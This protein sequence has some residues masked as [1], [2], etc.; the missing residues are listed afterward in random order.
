MQQSFNANMT[1]GLAFLTTTRTLLAD[2]AHSNIMHRTF[3]GPNTTF[4]MPKLTPEM[5]LEYVMNMSKACDSLQCFQDVIAYFDDNFFDVC[6]QI[7][8]AQLQQDPV[9]MGFGRRQLFTWLYIWIGVAAGLL[10]FGTI[11]LYLPMR[12]AGACMLWP[13]S[14]CF[15]ILATLLYPM[16]VLMSDTCGGI[17]HL[18][19]TI[20][21]TDTHLGLNTRELL[22]RNVSD[23]EDYTSLIPFA[24]FSIRYNATDV[25]IPGLPVLF[26]TYFG[27]CHSEGE[28]GIRVEDTVKEAGK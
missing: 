15:L 19:Y 20:V 27:S 10:I 13:V 8:A 22:M 2:T 6:A 4:K 23:I 17:E 16:T 5:D 24:N 12:C 25:V 14:F 26:E 1:S 18:A 7:V 11:F 21:S 9:K 28:G 3:Y